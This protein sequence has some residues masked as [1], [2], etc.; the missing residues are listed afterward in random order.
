[1]SEGYGALRLWST[2]LI[3]VGVLG[4]IFVVAE[5]DREQRRGMPAER[6]SEGQGMPRD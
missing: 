3:F 6:L 4:V 5:Y 1:M 2:V